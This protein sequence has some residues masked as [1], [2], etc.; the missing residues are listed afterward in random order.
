ML[1]H[2]EV[3]SA[4]RLSIDQGSDIWRSCEQQGVGSQLFLFL[5]P[6]L[7]LPVHVSAVVVGSAA[8][9]LPPYRVWLRLRFLTER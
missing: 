2:S 7:C 8:D 5:S 4:R 3:T 9:T 1:G 6:F